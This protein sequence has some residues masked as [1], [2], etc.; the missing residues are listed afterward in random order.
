MLYSSKAT[1][2]AKIA[3][4]KQIAKKSNALLLQPILFQ[5]DRFFQWRVPTE[6]LNKTN[7]SSYREQGEIDTCKSVEDA[8]FFPFKQ[9]GLF[10]HEPL[11]DTHRDTPSQAFQ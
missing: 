8:P 6:F 7:K 2:S 11:Q 4:K 5:C 1:I 3:I 9:I 10:L